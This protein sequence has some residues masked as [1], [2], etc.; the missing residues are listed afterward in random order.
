MTQ[1]VEKTPEELLKNHLVEIIFS[2]KLGATY[3]FPDVEPKVALELAHNFDNHQVHSTLTLVN[4]SE[5]CLVLPTRII[6][7]IDVHQRHLQEAP[8]ASWKRKT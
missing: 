5:A 2:T 7:Q 1:Y 3:S 8:F 6:N 4:V